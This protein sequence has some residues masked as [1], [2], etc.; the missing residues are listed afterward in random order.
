MARRPAVAIGAAVVGVAAVA[1]VAIAASSGSGASP[2]SIAGAWSDNNG[3]TFTFTSSG[4]V[5]YTVSLKTADNLKCAQPDDGTV[6]GSNGH[7]SGTIDL[8]P[9]NYTGPSGSCPPKTGLAQITIVL[10]ANGTT[11]SV[12]TDGDNCSECG[13]GTWSRE[14]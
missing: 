12:D 14:S 13:Q 9:Q 4:P 10:S 6:T 8:Y 7:F 11:A 3:G 2:L 1:G 5:S